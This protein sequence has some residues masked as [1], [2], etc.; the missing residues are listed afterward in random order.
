MISEE[1]QTALTAV[2]TRLAAVWARTG[3]IDGFAEEEIPRDRTEAYFAQDHLAALIGQPCSGW[4]IG[5]TSAKMRELEGHEDILP[6]RL[7]PSITHFA[8][9]LTLDIGECPNARVETEFGFRLLKDL[10][11]REAAWTA[12][13]IAPHILLH[14]SLEI[15]GNRFKRPDLD[16][17]ILSRM[18]IVDNGGCLAGLFGDPVEDWQGI[19]FQNHPV[20]F[21]VDDNP[22]AENFL[23][24]M[25]CQPP[26]AIAE[27]ANLLATRGLFLPK[28]S[29][30]LTGTATVPQPVKKGSSLVADFGTLGQLKMSFT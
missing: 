9:E 13:E 16:P 30:L 26:Q 7:F 19:D 8:N 18:G 15:I 17:A 27:L 28:D 5:A 14:P 10:P 23:G 11:L 4:K 6:G 2:A 22:P 12:E 25:R 1:R 24:E 3:L 21:I 29:M 20:S